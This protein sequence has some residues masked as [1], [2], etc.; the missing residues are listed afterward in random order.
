MER[1]T[2]TIIGAFR[3]RDDNEDKL[4]AAPVGLTFHQGQI[5]E[6]VYFVEKYFDSKV[7]ALVRRSCVVIPFRITPA[8][9][10]YQLLLQT[11]GFGSFPKGHME[12]FE[13]EEITALRELQE[14]TGFPAQLMIGFREMVSYPMHTGRT[15]QVVLFLGEVT[16]E[17]LLQQEEAVDFRWAAKEEAKQLLHPDFSNVMDQ[18]EVFLEEV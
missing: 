14:E 4:V 2:G 9:L 17:I 6:Q 12:P 15:K 13:T 10:R 18:A 8:G 1:F 16:G 5:G 11:N 3:R 7:D